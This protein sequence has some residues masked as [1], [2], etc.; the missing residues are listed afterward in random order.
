MKQLTKIYSLLVSLFAC[1][2]LWAQVP[3]ASPAQSSPMLISGGTVHVGNGEVVEQGMVIFENGK[4]TAVGTA[5]SLP[6]IDRSSYQVIDAS[7]KHVYPGFIA[8][9]TQLG[10]VE[11][12]AV[13]ATRDAREVG[14][15]NP[16]VRSIIAYN[17]DS[18]VIPTV[19]AQGVLLAQVTPEGGRVSGSSTIVQLDAWNWEDAAF[20]TDDGIHLNWPSEYRYSWRNRSFT[21][22][23]DYNDQVQGLYQFFDE[24]QAYTELE[25]PRPKNLKFSAMLGLF[26]GSK[27]LFVHTASAKTITQAVQMGK[28]YRLNVVIV[29]GRDAWMVTDLLKTNNVPVMLSETHSLPRQVDDA[30]DQPFRTPALLEEAGVSYCIGMDGYWQLRN[31]AFQAGHAVGFGL[32]YEKA[33]AAITLNTAKILGIAD[34]VGSIEK[35]KDATL[36]VTSG[37]ALDMRTSVVEHAFIQG[38]TVDLT[39]KQRELYEKFKT[40]YEQGQ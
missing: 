16:N 28:K 25:S 12:G 40:K 39:N 19:R 22:N 3:A 38:R 2:M 10:L 15:I 1:A 7:G 17:T 4:I 32:D 8:P 21:E 37:D 33:V 26:D 24:A 29:G 13:R 20:K 31:L 11:I 23:K 6:T 30:I 14:A 34:R 35:G 9:N 36:I 27:T 18:E 5:S